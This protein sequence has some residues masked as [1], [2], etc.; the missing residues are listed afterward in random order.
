LYIDD[1][2]D[3]ISSLRAAGNQVIAFDRVYNRHLDGLRVNRWSQVYDIVMA[4]ADRHATA[5]A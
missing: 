5:A 1:G 4:A 3:N 2:A